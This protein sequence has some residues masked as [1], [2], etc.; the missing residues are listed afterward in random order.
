MMTSRKSYSANKGM[1]STTVQFDVGG[2]VYRVSR[3]LL[4]LF[5]DTMLSRM[6]SKT[7]AHDDDDGRKEEI[8]IFIERNAERFQYVLDYMRD[9]QVVS[10]PV[11]VSKKGFLK[12]LE[13]YGF[14]NVDASSVSLCP[15][16]STYL[17]MGEKFEKLEAESCERK[18]EEHRAATLAHYSFL[19]VLYS[20]DLTFEIYRGSATFAKHE[21]KRYEDPTVID[22]LIK[23]ARHISIDNFDEA[24]NQYGLECASITMNNAPSNPLTIKLGI[25]D[26]N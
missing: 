17:D 4:E 20:G 25:I 7:W 1:N 12:D 24:L 22:E 8:P 16:L 6:V 11:T 5:P 23:I 10:L 2:R 26:G 9:G 14:E 21:H 19:R 18:D 13:Y 15:S 3:S